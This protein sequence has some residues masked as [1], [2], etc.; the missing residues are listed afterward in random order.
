VVLRFPGTGPS[1]SRI[2]PTAILGPGL[3]LPFPM[4]CNRL[5][6]S[7]RGEAADHITINAP[8]RSPE[9]GDRHGAVYNLRFSLGLDSTLR[10]Q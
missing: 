3:D 6:V 4:E 1:G 8:L 2:L 10:R 7:A 9:S 5:P